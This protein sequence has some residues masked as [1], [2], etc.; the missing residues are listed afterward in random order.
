MSNKPTVLKI[1]KTISGL[2]K[3]ESQYKEI[4]YGGSNPYS[5]CSECERSMIEVSYKGHFKGC[6]KAEIELA[7]KKFE[8]LYQQELQTFLESKEYESRSFM[9]YC[10][11]KQDLYVEGLHI[12]EDEIKKHKNTLKKKLVILTVF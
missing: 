11:F 7:I 3:K 2:R 8:S 1:L 10:W 9:N 5:Y 6:A 12:L 4:P